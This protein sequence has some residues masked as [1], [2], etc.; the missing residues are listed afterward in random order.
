MD[1]GINQF[2]NAE[3]LFY[4]GEYEKAAA[5]F[6]KIKGDKRFAP[7]CFNY[8]AK[9]SNTLSDPETAYNLYCKAFELM[10]DLCSKTLPENHS[11]HKYVF[12]GMKEETERT[13]CFL[14]GGE[15]A[16]KWCYLLSEA[17][18]FNKIFNP[19]RMWMHCA[20]CN[21]MFA[22]NFPEKLFIYNNSPRKANPQFFP[23]YSEILS[24]ITSNG[25]ANGMSLFEVGIGACE[26][27][28]A[29]KE[30]GYDAFGIDV[31]E[32]HVED[33][34]NIYGLNAE[35]ADF[36]EFESAQRWDIIIMG[37][38]IEHVSDPVTALKKAEALL[39]DDGALWVSTP[40]FESAY[41]IAVGHD[42]PMKKQQYHLN[43]F[44]RDSFYKVLD[45]CGFAPVDYRI[46]AHYNGSMEV[47]AVKKTRVQ[48]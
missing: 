10:P 16:P 5:L 39:A 48:V 29:A 18:G 15:A 9:I 40:N 35:A 25:Y 45:E 28:L 11:S 24:R 20:G 1:A 13:T 7:Y 17:G 27:L 23:Y 41:S 32:R 3:T 21:H 12:G 26:C 43:Y 19:V 4:D 37:D 42:D 8:L 31:I 34:K 22:R 33:A 46:S 38:V 6:L 47:I 2:Q 14:C 44:S 30:M 36:N